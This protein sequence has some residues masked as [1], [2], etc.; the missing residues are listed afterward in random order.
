MFINFNCFYSMLTVSCSIRSYFDNRKS[1]FVYTYRFFFTGRHLVVPL[2]YIYIFPFLPPISATFPPPFSA[3]FVFSC[4]STIWFPLL[5]VTH[6]YIY[7]RW[8]A[9]PVTSMPRRRANA[10]F[11]RAR[12]EKRMCF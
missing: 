7:F 2:F 3:N 10:G 9:D 6:A 12:E 8:L 1:C 5:V 4:V 11:V